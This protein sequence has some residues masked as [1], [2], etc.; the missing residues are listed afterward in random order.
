MN[1]PKPPLLEGIHHASDQPFHHR[2]RH[3]RTATCPAASTT[4]PR[5]GSRPS[6]S[7]R[8]SP[9]VADNDDPDFRTRAIDHQGAALRAG[10]AP[11]LGA[12]DRLLQAPALREVPPAAHPRSTRPPSWPAPAA[13]RAS[14]TR[15]RPTSCS[16]RSPRSTPSSRRPRPPEPCPHRRS[17]LHPEA[18]PCCRCGRAVADVRAM[19]PGICRRKER[20]LGQA[21]PIDTRRAAYDASYR[22]VSG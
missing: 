12:V 18:G 16:P 21:F 20:E 9:K 10:Q 13:P 4:R 5:P 2:E 14:S 15:P 17:R 7:R 19:T 11:P 3:R 8:S 22:S 1:G 6:R